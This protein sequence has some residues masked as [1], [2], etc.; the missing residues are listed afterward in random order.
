VQVP[1]TAPAPTDA[2][3]SPRAPDPHPPAGGIGPEGEPVGGAALTSRGLVVPTGVP[4]VPA[5]MSAQAWILV[6]LDSGAVL[7]GRDVHGRYQP[8]SILKTLTS[9]TLLPHLP[10]NQVVTVS[11]AAANT[12]GSHAG[13]VPGGQYTVDQL[14]SGMLLVSGNDAAVALADAYGGV[15]KTVAAMNAE[16]LSLGAYD[17]FVQT[18]SGLDGWQQ[19]TSAYDMALFLRAALAQPRFAAYDEQPTAELPAQHVDGGLDAVKLVNQNNIFFSSV[20]GALVAKT[21][22]TDAASHTALFATD[23]G[24]RRLG[25]VMLRAQRWPQDQWQQAAALLNWGYALPAGTPPVGQLAAAV[26]LAPAATA[27]SHP[28]AHTS[29]GAA[30]GRVDAAGSGSRPMSASVGLALALVALVIAAAVG[31][32]DLRHRLRRRSLPAD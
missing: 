3:N 24:G 16:A 6:D 25:V 23:R 14:F 5:S 27:A 19:L 20:P 17:T 4:A 28:A 9:V 1:P 2:G 30:A 29:N 12:E 22:Y 7:A 13:L 11:A 21:G 8:A 26:H 32:A 10:G 31:G 15:S 18:P